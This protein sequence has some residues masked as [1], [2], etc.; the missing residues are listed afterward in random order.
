MDGM[1]N[2]KLLINVCLT[3][4]V[5]SKEDNPKLPVTPEEIVKDVESCHNLGAQIFHIH[6]RDNEGIPTW[7]K[8][9]YQQIINAIRD[10]CPEIILCVSTS[11]RYWSE[12]DKRAE[13]LDCENVDMASLT[14]GSMNFYKSVSN[15]SPDIIRDLLTRINERN[16]KPELEVFD[17]GHLF[18]AHRLIKE[19]LLKPPY[20]FNILLGSPWSMPLQLD[21]VSLLIRNMPEDSI[22]SFAGIGKFQYEANLLGLL[23]ANGVRIG[24]EDNL[25]M[26]GEL[27]TNEN[28]VSQI[29]LIADVMNRRLATVSE[30]KETILKEK[31]D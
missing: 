26:S 2:N 24:L 12:I 21:I 13:C 15:N 10:K 8:E 6:A 31:A 18:F 16:I 5:H 19:G 1:L 7:K 3:G 20:Y 28:L 4:C 9:S 14:L 22:F 29:V 11:G 30:A 25:K 17:I 27:T 23:Y